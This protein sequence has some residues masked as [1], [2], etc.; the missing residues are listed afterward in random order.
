GSV[1]C[2]AICVKASRNFGWTHRL[3]QRP[4]SSSTECACC[5]RGAET[6][7]RDG[8]RTPSLEGPCP[9]GETFPGGREEVGGR[10]SPNPGPFA[11]AAELAPS[12]PPSPWSLSAAANAC[13]S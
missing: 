11:S 9:R 12:L 1:I 2:A 10:G 8:D 6:I 13:E 4:S 5:Q 7:H 3:R